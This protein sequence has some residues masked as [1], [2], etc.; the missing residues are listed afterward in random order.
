M[1][2][3][4]QEAYQIAMRLLAGRE[5]SQRELS[6]KLKSRGYAQSVIDACIDDLVSNNL[7]CDERYTESL[8]RSCIRRGKGLLYIKKIMQERGGSAQAMLIWCDQE[9]FD[10]TAHAIAVLEKKFGAYYCDEINKAKALRFLK[11][12]GFDERTICSVLINE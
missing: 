6:T 12:R 9:A 11:S 2:D 1:S 10:W 3:D 7:Q 4:C 8:I 5:H